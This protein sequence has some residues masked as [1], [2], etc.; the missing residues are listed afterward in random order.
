[1]LR[2]KTVLVALSVALPVA[3]FSTAHAAATEGTHTQAYSFAD[4]L[5][6]GQQVARAED[7]VPMRSVSNLRILAAE[8]R[9]GYGGVALPVTV[10]GITDA[11]GDKLDDDGKVD[12]ALF[13]A[14]ACLKLWSSS[15][16]VANGTCTLS[17]ASTNAVRASAVGVAGASRWYVASENAWAAQG[18][19]TRMHAYNLTAIR[20]GFTELR[21]GVTVRGLVD[22]NKNGID[23][24][25]RFK[26]TNGTSSVCVQLSSTGG[27][28]TFPAC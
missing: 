12:V 4:G 7:G 18:Y 6:G 8:F 25:G 9:N 24:D 26:V 1:M 22:V 14:K 19:G 10:S 23:D 3:A 20:S 17:T 15:Y 16:T 5:G 11:N 21:A 27:A 28:A 2:I 13:G